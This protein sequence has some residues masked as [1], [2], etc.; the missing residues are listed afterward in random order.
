M[1]KQND[2][3]LP[4]LVNISSHTSKGKTY[5]TSI[6]IILTC[7]VVDTSE[8]ENYLQIDTMSYTTFNMN[9]RECVCTLVNKIT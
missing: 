3:P 1:H 2:I 8:Y 6:N 9:V 4:I 5:H 7:I